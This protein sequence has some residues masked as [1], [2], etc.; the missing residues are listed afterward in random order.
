VVIKARARVD[1]RI[2]WGQ[3]AVVEVLCWLLPAGFRDRQRAEWVG[4]LLAMSQ[5]GVSAAGRRRYLFAAAWTL[6]V[7]RAHARPPGVDYVVAR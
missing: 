1:D 3:R 5:A 7:L 2:G 4:D 6:P